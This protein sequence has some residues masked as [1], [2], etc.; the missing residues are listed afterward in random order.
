MRIGFFELHYPTKGKTEASKKNWRKKREDIFLSE[1]VAGRTVV[2]PFGFY[3]RI[4]IRNVCPS[5]TLCIKELD[6]LLVKVV[7]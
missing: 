4:T 5:S 3:G 7:L 6:L 1:P 2:G